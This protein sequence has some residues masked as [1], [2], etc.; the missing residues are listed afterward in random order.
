MI[1]TGGTIEAAYWAVEAAGARREGVI[2]AATHGLFVGG[3]VNK[4]RGL[5]V[6][7]ILVT[8]SVLRTPTPSVP[9]ETVS[10][11]LLLAKAIDGLRQTP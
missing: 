3:C 10:I 7:R 2:V 1:S 4:L 5:E 11:A 6:K 9:V 8:D